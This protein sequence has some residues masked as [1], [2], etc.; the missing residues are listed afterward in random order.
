MRELPLRP[1]SSKRSARKDAQGKNWDATTFSSM[2]LCGETSMEES[3]FGNCANWGA[4]VIGTGMFTPWTTTIPGRHP[5]L[6]Q[7]LQERIVYRGQRMVNWCPAS[8]AGLSDEVIMK[9]QNSTLY[10]IKYGILETPG[11]FRRGFH[12]QTE[13]IM[14][15]VALAIHPE[16]PQLGESQSQ[17]RHP[18]HKPSSDPHHCGRGGGKGLWHGH[19]QDYS[20]S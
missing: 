4:P 19:S 18:P 11:S 14:G 5:D 7:T 9:P 17:A 20:R 2:R 1:K 12:H 3:S 15:G 13:T 10:R 8:L 16:D 6:C